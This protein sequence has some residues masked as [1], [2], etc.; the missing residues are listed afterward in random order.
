[1]NPSDD[2]QRTK[3]WRLMGSVFERLL[4]SKPADLAERLYNDYIT[5]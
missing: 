4:R 2:V 3:A 1:M 5:T